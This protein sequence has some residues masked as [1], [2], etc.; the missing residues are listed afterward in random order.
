MTAVTQQFKKRIWVAA[1]TILLGLG[2]IGVFVPVLPT[3]PFLLL[4]AF[5]YLKGSRRLYES[6]LQNRFMGNYLRNYLEGRGMA[7]KMKIWT[8]SLLWITIMA[9]A[10]FITDNF[11]VRIILAAVLFGVTVHII[12]V[13]TLKQ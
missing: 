1:G 13:K 5:C 10:I 7:L 11:I 6:L 9:S 4:A 8:L 2:M 12:V 3:T